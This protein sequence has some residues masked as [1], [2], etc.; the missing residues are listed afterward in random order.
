MSTSCEGRNAADFQNNL[1]S[2]DAVEGN[3][4]EDDSDDGNNGDFEE[5]VD[6]TVMEVTRAKYAFA[7]SEHGVSVS[8]TPLPLVRS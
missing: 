8:Y 1:S 3:S 6:E 7:T 2:I 5:I 4:D